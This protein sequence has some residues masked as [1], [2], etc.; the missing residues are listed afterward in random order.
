MIRVTVIR[1]RTPKV[2]LEKDVLKKCSKFTGEQPCR[3]V[4]SMKLLRNEKQFY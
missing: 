1:S 3:C 4:I 2:F